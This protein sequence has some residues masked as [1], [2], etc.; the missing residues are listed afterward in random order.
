MIRLLSRPGC[1]LRLLVAATALAVVV[2]GVAA[3]KPLC[4][5]NDENSD[6][7]VLT[8]AKLKKGK[9]TAASGYVAREPNPG[10]T[11]GSADLRRRD[12]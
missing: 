3:A 9:V 5:S 1:N 4:L 11:N 8:N 2:P 12:R 7:V 6:I 10:V